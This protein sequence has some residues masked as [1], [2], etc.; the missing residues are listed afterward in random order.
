MRQVRPRRLITKLTIPIASDGLSKAR[1]RPPA[2][3]TVTP[4]LTGWTDFRNGPSNPNAPNKNSQADAM[5]PYCPG[6][7]HPVTLTPYIPS[8]LADVSSPDGFR[9]TPGAL[10]RLGA[11]TGHLRHRHGGRLIDGQGRQ[12][13]DANGA[14][15][16]P[17][18]LASRPAVVVPHH[19][20][21]SPTDNSLPRTP[22]YPP[23]SHKSLPQPPTL[24]RPGLTS[25]TLPLNQEDRFSLVR[26]LV[27]AT[28][29][30]FTLPLSTEFP[31]TET[32]Q[33]RAVKVPG[34]TRIRY[35]PNEVSRVA[36]P[37]LTPITTITWS[38]ITTPHIPTPSSSILTL[39]LTITLTLIMML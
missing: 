30:R 26:L 37:A 36:Y 17:G 14:E 28:S 27:V 16:S 11:S 6:I 38:R 22:Q 23:T 15:R 4:T 31:V 10:K 25:R 13:L 35:F 9:G 20:S 2:S 7:Y 33:I 12:V 21:C 8:T 34:T 32:S 3:Q 1:Y 29:N 39:T 18:Q 19:N 24:S 5:D